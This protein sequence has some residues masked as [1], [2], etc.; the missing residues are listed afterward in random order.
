[1]FD[2]KSYIKHLSIL[3]SGTFFVQILNFIS[4]P[5]LS[6]LYSPSE[7]G[8]YSVILA[9][10]MTISAI[11]CCRFEVLI[12]S[13]KKSE[14]KHVLILSQLVNIFSLVGVAVLG[15]LLCYFFNFI[16]YLDVLFVSIAIFFTALNNSL[17]VFLLRIEKYNV[18]IN[19]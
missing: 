11:S 7:F 12:L 8:Q 2:A 9:V 19:S 13:S 1:M 14:F 4:Y 17:L 16:S 15:S 5:I 6:K 3:M 10:I 18:N